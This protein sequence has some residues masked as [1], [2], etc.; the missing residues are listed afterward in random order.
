MTACV[1]S[2][3]DVPV[4]PQHERGSGL[5]LGPDGEPVAGAIVNFNDPGTGK[6]IAGSVTGDDGRFMPTVP[7]GT[8]VVTA[9]TVSGW[10]SSAG[11]EVSNAPL[12]ISLGKDCLRYRGQVE[13]VANSEVGATIHFKRITREFNEEFAIHA[14]KRNFEICLPPGDFTVFAAGDYLS[15]PQL[16]T[17][18]STELSIHAFSRSTVLEPAPESGVSRG[19]D[20]VRFVEQVPSTVSIVAIGESNHG[21]REF[22]ELRHKITMQLVQARGF[23]TL[24]IE[25]GFGETLALN[26]FIHGEAVDVRKAVELLGYW[27]WDTEEFLKVLDALRSYNATVPAAD[28]VNLWGLDVQHTAASVAVLTAVDDLSA[29][30]RGLIGKLGSERGAAWKTFSDADRTIVLEAIERLESNRSDHLRSLAARA[31]R[32]RLEATTMGFTAAILHRDVGMARMALAAASVSSGGNVVVWAHNAHVAREAIDGFPMMGHH[33]ARS[34]GSAYFPI[35]LYTAAGHARAWDERGAVGVVSHEISTPSYRVERA[36]LDATDGR[37]GLLVGEALPGVLKRWLSVP[38]YALEFGASFDS[39]G[40][41]R[42]AL[43]AYSAFGIVPISSP[44]TPTPTGVRTAT[45]PK[46]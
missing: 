42:T 21:T 45:P 44:T 3:R 11:V 19:L 24:M 2:H 10:Y 43:V 5:V 26:R 35:A 8:Y 18:G 14:A 31:L 15:V 22:L 34:A 37:G 7:P 12:S 6:L 30:E 25:A 29:A 23:R 46:P 9:A 13:N 17:E 20:P 36:L 28:R 1:G 27:M 33:I 32:Q 41:L 39:T 16:V 38:R 40:H 4:K